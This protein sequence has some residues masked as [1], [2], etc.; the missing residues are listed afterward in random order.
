MTMN[1]DKIKPCRHCGGIA[2]FTVEQDAWDI[3]HVWLQ[4]R[5]CRAYVI[6]D[7]ALKAVELW[8]NGEIHYAKQ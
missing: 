1:P 7:N 5:K 6:A 2:V 3:E 4:C 8:N